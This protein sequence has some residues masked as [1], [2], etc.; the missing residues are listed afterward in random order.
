MKYWDY[1]I[2][3]FSDDDNKIVIA[4][5]ALTIALITFLLNFIIK[6]IYKKIIGYFQEVK[7]EVGISHQFIQSAFGSSVGTPLLT[8]TITNKTD[9]TIYINNPSIK[10]SRKINNEDKFVVPKPAGMFPK[11]L[12]VGEQFGLDY[13]TNSMYNQ[14][15]SKLSSNDKISAIITTT[16]NKKYTSN[17]ISQNRIVEHMNI[18]NTLN[19]R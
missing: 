13:D 10:T 7:V 12:E 6:P 16:S 1:Y 19:R 11:K 8:V 5:W 18:P 15:L 3:L 9:K 2:S 4:I 14:I 17:S